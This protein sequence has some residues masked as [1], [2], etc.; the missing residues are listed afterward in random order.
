MNKKHSETSLGRMMRG[1]GYFVHKWRDRGFVSCPNC[2][3]TLTVCPKCKGSLLLPK[4]Q[5]YPDFLVAHSWTFIECKQGIDNWSLLDI[6]ET[7]VSVL[8]ESNQPSWIFLELGPGKAPKGKQAY[9]IAWQEFKRI[10]HEIIS[11]Q[12]IKSVCF[13][14]SAR[15]RAPQAD[16]VFAPYQLEW[17]TLQGWT[18]P[19]THCWWQTVWRNNDLTI[20]DGNTTTSNNL[21]LLG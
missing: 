18:I 17:A 12:N 5:T 2:H 4:A 3:T 15:G 14:R 8:D 6:S 10:R 1:H 20:V 21:R 11:E 9:L 13:R 7:Q 16:E 19:Q